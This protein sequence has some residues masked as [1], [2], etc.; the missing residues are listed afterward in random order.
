MYVYYRVRPAD[1]P[2]AIATVRRLQAD[3]QAARPD[4]ACTLSQRATNTADAV[5]LMETYA[6]ASGLPQAWQQEIE[7]SA[8]MQLATWLVGGRQVEVFVPCA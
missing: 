4:L 2:Q 7:R 6:C 8:S 5:T 1:A 3:W